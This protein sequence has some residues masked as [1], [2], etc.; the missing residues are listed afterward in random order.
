APVVLIS[1]RLWM[2]R[3]ASDP[4][5]VGQSIS[6][7]SLPHT[8]AGILPD[9]FQ[10]PVR[11]I[12]V[13]FPQPANTPFVPQQFHGCCTPL[14]GVAR[15]RAG[16]T[17]AQADA[18]LS[19]LNGRYEPKDQPRVDA[20]AALFAPLKDTIVGPI[21]TMLWLLMAAVGFVLLIACANVAT[22]LMARATART[23]EFALRTA[24]GAG[25]SR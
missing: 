9:G 6:I 4:A 10:F 3:F 16:T 2:R 22:L 21:D 18:E 17:R 13:W 11:A 14:M 20:G 5:I 8:V 7:G 19:V 23:R 15:L 1:E 24:L 12:D 25:R